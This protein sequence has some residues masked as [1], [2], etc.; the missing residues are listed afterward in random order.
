MGL[1]NS[2]Q[3]TTPRHILQ[4]NGGLADFWY[5][6]DGDILCHPVLGSFD[7]HEFDDTNDK[8]GAERNPQKTEVI[9]YVADLVRKLP[10]SPQG[11]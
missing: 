8:V 3:L 2:P 5:I 10:P 9:Y 4:E 1:N 6:D 7:L 11:R